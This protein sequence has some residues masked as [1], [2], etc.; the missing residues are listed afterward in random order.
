MRY[1]ALTWMMIQYDQWTDSLEAARRFV[2]GASKGYLS[3]KLKNGRGYWYLQYRE[4]S[5]IL[6]QYVGTDDEKKVKETATLIEKRREEE[7]YIRRMER[8][9]HVLRKAIRAIIARIA[10]RISRRKDRTMN[11]YEKHILTRWSRHATE[12]AA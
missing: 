2:A 11:E 3:R 7:R 10:K 12:R 8:E 1:A 4:G 5:R 6:S 9:L